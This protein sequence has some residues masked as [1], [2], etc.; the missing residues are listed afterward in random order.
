[1]TRPAELQKIIEEADHTIAQ[2]EQARRR[3]RT[4]VEQLRKATQQAHMDRLYAIGRLVFE[5]GMDDCEDEVLAGILLAAGETM[6][7]KP[8]ARDSWKRRG[9]KALAERR[10]P[11]ALEVLF[12]DRPDRSS[13]A[14]LR[15]AGLSKAE[16][17]IRDGQRWTV[18][19]GK[20]SRRYLERRLGDSGA[21][22][23]SATS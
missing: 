8:T 20:A 2:A 21:V 9:A 18:Y 15:G 4:A 6:A 12:P 17:T 22:I 3:R 14:I 16:S 10:R 19:R 7:S 5:V 11:V 1:M 23:R 13:S